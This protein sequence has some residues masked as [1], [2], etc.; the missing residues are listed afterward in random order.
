MKRLTSILLSILLVFSCA[1]LSVSAEEGENLTVTMLDVGQGLS[2]LF[3]SDGEYMLYD[4]GGR[5]SSSYV[6]AYLK[7]HG[8]TELDYL[9][10]SHY[11]EDHIAGL[12][13]VL[14]TTEVDTVINPDY[15]N[16]TK[17]YSSFVSKREQSKA[18]V[19]YPGIG[20][21]FTFGDSD[22]TVI[23][24]ENYDCEDKNSASVVLRIRCGDFSCIITGDAEED[25][26]TSMV[27]SDYDIDCDLYIVGHHGSSSSSSGDFVRAMSPAYSFISVGKDNSYGHPTE[28]T[29]NTLS[30]Y[31]S[32]IYRTDESGE[33]TLTYR[34]GNTEIFTQKQ[35]YFTGGGTSAESS[36]EAVPEPV[37]QAVSAQY[38]LKIN[39]KKFHYPDCGS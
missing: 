13:G 18:E 6:V 30:A 39:T 23:S 24:P 11:D 10:A 25:A 35:G 28:R 36:S 12:V 19:I 22:I 34:D 32:E 26:E 16:D 8:I 3:E 27:Y 31:N 4:G 37:K 5:N 1:V 14:N 38:V 9:V 15:V 20:D 2:V 7:Q 17:I 29:L 21:S 33:I